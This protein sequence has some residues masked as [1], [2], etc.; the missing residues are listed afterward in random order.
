[1]RS[2][3][4]LAIAAL[5][6]IVGATVAFAAI[7]HSTT[8]VITGCYKTNAPLQGSVRVVDAEA[9]ASCPSGYTQLAWSQTGPQGPTGP[10]GATGPSGVSG[11]EWVVEPNVEI[12]GGTPGQSVEVD[13]PSGKAPINGSFEATSSDITLWT[14]HPSSH[15]LPSGGFWQM[16]FANSHENPRFVTVAVLCINLP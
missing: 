10:Q 12:A 5:L 9:G 13:C 11:L 16:K 15:S 14:S 6:I 2:R 3:I 1:M 8:G 4:V 7:P